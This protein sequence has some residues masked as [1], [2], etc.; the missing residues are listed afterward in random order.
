M[1]S[2][3]IRPAAPKGPEK[4][5]IDGWKFFRISLVNGIFIDYNM[6]SNLSFT[7]VLVTN[8]SAI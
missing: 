7:V 1:V 3:T 4:D 5:G 8:V 6:I 2:D